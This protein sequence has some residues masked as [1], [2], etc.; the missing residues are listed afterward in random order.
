MRELIDA[1]LK[2]GLLKVGV[3]QVEPAEKSINPI[4][5]TASQPAAADNDFEMVEQ[6]DKFDTD[7]ESTE[8]EDDEDVELRNPSMIVIEKEKKI[9]GNALDEDDEI[10]EQKRKKRKKLDELINPQTI[11]MGKDKEE[12]KLKRVANTR[13]I[14]DLKKKRQ[15]HRTAT[16]ES[17]LLLNEKLE[18]NKIKRLRN[19]SS[20]KKKKKTEQVWTQELILE[21]SK[22]TEILNL[23]SL[24]KYKLEEEELKKKMKD[25]SKKKKLILKGP[26]ISYLSYK[27][28]FVEEVY[29]DENEVEA[30]GVSELKDSVP[31]SSISDTIIDVT[32]SIGDEDAGEKKTVETELAKSND[33]K[34]DHKNSI[35][36]NS[37]LC[38]AQNINTLEN[39][40]LTSTFLERGLGGEE[41]PMDTSVLKEVVE[42]SEVV[43]GNTTLHDKKSEVLV[44]ETEKTK[45]VSTDSDLK[46]SKNIAVNKP[47]KNV[48]RFFEKIPE[49]KSGRAKVVIENQT[50]PP[51]QQRNYLIFYNFKEDPFK[52]LT[53][54]P[55]YP[56][57]TCPITGLPAKY[58][59]P[60]TLVPYANL[61]AYKI[62]QKV[63]EGE[64]LWS[65]LL[66][67]YLNSKIYEEKFQTLPK[68]LISN[69]GYL[70]TDTF[71]IDEDFA[72]ST[73]KNKE[74]KN[75]ETLDKGKKV[76]GGAE[77]KTKIKKDLP[78]NNV[79]TTMVGLPGEKVK[80]VTKNSKYENV[81]FD[82]FG[83][84]V[85]AA[86]GT[87]LPKIISSKLGKKRGK[88]KPRKKSTEIVSDEKLFQQKMQTKR[89]RVNEKKELN[90]QSGGIQPAQSQH[91]LMKPMF[92]QVN[93][94]YP[95]LMGRFIPPHHQGAPHLFAG[96]VDQE[97]LN[98][99]PTGYPQQ[100]MPNFGQVGQQRPHYGHLQ[101]QLPLQGSYYYESQN[102]TPAITEDFIKV[103]D[104][105]GTVSTRGE[106]KKIADKL[107]SSKQQENNEAS[108]SSDE[109]VEEEDVLD[110]IKK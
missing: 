69:Y 39:V 4:V 11:V 49:K 21:E 55:T 23:L 95:H 92:Q 102:C 12:R 108:E 30:L 71:K 27:E 43:E 98:Q 67:T 50:V 34:S 41:L 80:V 40:D 93:P 44:C 36:E 2:A 59:C 89:K 97:Q 22:Q 57:S 72:V 29:S 8:E 65:T 46:N 51:P 63:Q 32:K 56:D 96:Q 74:K 103:S 94:N 18:E 87:I 109:D 24:D 88:Y 33:E 37:D 6:F 52:N 58:R 19:Q 100:L 25:S 90:I 85:N 99:I 42:S 62:L 76:L 28:V 53:T 16:V 45:A 105:D 14:L 1:Q 60:K 48:V 47:V 10:R 17:T 7:F 26:I 104:I 84:I 5:E 77:K 81:V 73:E 78:V 110:E 13:K 15:S 68:G 82:E 54:K 20:H 75:L 101:N 86:D 38:T 83:N 35:N 66:G 3:E 79:N 64:Y 106:N 31:S 70:K 91:Q 9:Q 107:E 61:E